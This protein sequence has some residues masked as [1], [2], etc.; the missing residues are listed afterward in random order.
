MRQ[1]SG[2]M[3]F[4]K[5]ALLAVCALAAVGA[6]IS[7]AGSGWA[8]DDSS[9]PQPRDVEDTDGWLNFVDYYVAEDGEIEELRDR[10]VEDIDGADHRV[11][12]AVHYLDD[13]RIS[14]ALRRANERGV[15]VRMVADA[16]YEDDALMRDFADHDAYDGVEIVFGDGELEYL[17]E[18]N[19]SPLLEHCRGPQ[20]HPDEYGHDDFR[21]CT[22]HD[23]EHQLLEL[24]NDRVMV[25]PDH[26][27]EMSHT[28]FLIDET[29]VWNLTARLGEPHD[30]GL[31]EQ[32]AWLAFRAMSEELTRSFEREF[33]QMHGGVFS[34]TLSVYNGPLKSITHQEPLRLTN[35]G[36]LRVRF[37]PQERLV[38]NVVDETYRA[39]SSVFVMTESLTNP[40]LIEA[41]KYKKENGFDVRVLLGQSRAEAEEYR[42]AL[43][44]LEPVEA[45]AQMGRLPTMV[46]IDSEL[47]RQ[48][49]QRPRIVQVLSHELWHA[50][51]FEVII[52]TGT[53][54]DGDSDWVRYYPSDTFA[55]GVMWE[56]EESGMDGDSMRNP[57]LDPFV[58]Q[59]EQMW[60]RAQ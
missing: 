58:E 24:N 45:P 28:F 52:N 33:R 26:Y 21:E 17:P 51:P 32:Q 60:S 40:D 42:Q 27:N 37:N 29:I 19:V 35:R 49:Q 47:D 23:D 7:V 39:R 44:P 11:D 41:L 2:P 38:K 59:F 8:D 43:E 30:T 48:G 9:E 15:D 12:V 22:Q 18:P 50:E 5:W 54:R 46:V 14:E 57:E 56:L 20:S 31:E 10:L 53:D 13:L 25:R 36:Q 3:S 55:D 34:T 1:M 16:R 4:K 6:T